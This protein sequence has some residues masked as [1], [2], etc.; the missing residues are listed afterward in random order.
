MA[1]AQ[2]HHSSCD[3]SAA[4][5]TRGKETILST[6]ATQTQLSV[7]FQTKTGSPAG[8]SLV[9]HHEL[10]EPGGREQP[11]AQ[12]SCSTQLQRRAH[13]LSCK[14]VLTRHRHVKHQL[15]SKGFPIYP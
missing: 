3:V 14:L 8:K 11:L 12:S 1:W 6:Q 13:L 4:L 15:G 2:G 5:Q 7:S 9:L 10:P